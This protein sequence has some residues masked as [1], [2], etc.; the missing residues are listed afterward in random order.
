MKGVIDSYRCILDQKPGRLVAYK[1][2][3]SKIQSIALFTKWI[4]IKL[5]LNALKKIFLHWSGQFSY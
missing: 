3:A 4:K 1:C 2:K 5:N